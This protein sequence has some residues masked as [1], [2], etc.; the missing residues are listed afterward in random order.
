MN[1]LT[2]KLTNFVTDFP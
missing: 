1:W 2:M